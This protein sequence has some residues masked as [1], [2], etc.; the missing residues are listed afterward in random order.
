MELTL[1]NVKQMYEFKVQSVLEGEGAVEKGKCSQWTR[2]KEL[3]NEKDIIYIKLRITYKGP[4]SQTILYTQFHLEDSEGYFSDAMPPEDYLEKVLGPHEYAEGGLLFSY[5]R[6]IR[7][8]RLWFDTRIQYENTIDP[9]LI[10]VELPLPEAETRTQLFAREELAQSYTQEVGS[11]FEPSSFPFRETEKLLKQIS[12]SCGI[13]YRRITYGYLLRVL[14]PE[15][16]KQNVILNFSGKDDA[17]NNLITIGTICG[18]VHNSNN[19]RVFLKLNPKMAYGAIGLSTI[20]GN[21]FYVITET[22][23]LSTISSEIVSYA[24]KN[25]AAK[26]DW[27]E[28]K[29]TGG[30]DIL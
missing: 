13:P 28:N 24:I 26:G 20:R 25:I 23:P 10:D 17:G 29:L 9:I 5:Y 22:Y 4:N 3:K 18:P 7:P 30:K 12:H 27:L 14:L 19:D 15:G 1:E 11:G 2:R 21:E 6:D 16:R 8:A